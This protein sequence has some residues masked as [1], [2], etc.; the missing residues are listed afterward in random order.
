MT[1]SCEILVVSGPN[2]AGKTTMAQEY[3]NT[4]GYPYIG[5]DAIAAS[6]APYDPASQR[7]AAGR[8]FM[9]EIAAAIEHKQSI[10]VE[11]T[12][13]GRTFA[14]T[15]HSARDAAFTVSLVHLFLDSADTCVARVVERVLKGGHDVP[16]QDIRRRFTRSAANFWHLYRPLCD[17]WVLMYNSITEAQPVAEGDS[18]THTVQDKELFDSFMQMVQIDD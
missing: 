10:V 11:S 6:L 16:E 9:T 1:A 7:V 5:A 2:G 18:V 17:R 4:L 3:S 14:Q 15:L 12:L 13:S 8:Q